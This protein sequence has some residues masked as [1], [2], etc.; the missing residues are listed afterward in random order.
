V[1][2][3]LLRGTQT[4]Q[5]DLNF[6]TGMAANGQNMLRAVANSSPTHQSPNSL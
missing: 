5:T 3:H 4:R 1:L 6:A 2:L